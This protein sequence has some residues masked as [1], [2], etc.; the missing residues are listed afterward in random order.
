MSRIGESRESRVV[1]RSTAGRDDTRERDYDD[2]S[3]Q[4]LRAETRE[5]P[6]VTRKTYRIPR[7]REEEEREE[8]I[9]IVGGGGSDRRSERDRGG[10]E[11]NRVVIRRERTPEPPQPERRDREIRVIERE[12]SPEPRRFEREYRYER[13]FDRRDDLERDFDRRDD[14]ER[15][16]R[17]VEY[18]PRPDPPQPIIIRQEPQQII[19][20]EAPRPPLVLPA[21]A[22]PREENFEVI[23][24]SEVQRSERSEVGGDRLVCSTPEAKR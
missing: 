17:S 12:R 7:E 1:Y 23:Q 14:L 15:Y 9:T 3:S 10:F 22:P 21:P 18:F 5:A 24:R 2:R 16:T 4:F 6:Y 8:R 19:I 13:D 11:E 20:Q